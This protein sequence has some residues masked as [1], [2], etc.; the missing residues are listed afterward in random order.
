[1]FSEIN[2]CR[3]CHNANL[4]IVLSLGEQSLTGVFPRNTSDNIPIGPLD[5]VWCTKCG[6]LQLKQSYSLDEMY[7]DNYGYRSGLNAYMVRHLTNKIK[8]LKNLAKL[9]GGD[10]VLDIGSNDATLLKAYPGKYKRVGIDPTGI[11]FK[12]FY[13]DG[14]EVIPDFSPQKF[15]LKNIRTH[16]QKL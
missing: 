3:I 7:G 11:K 9:S 15:L 16:K 2:K 8:T 10:L 4:I 12:D 6:L 14:I 1:M 5:L 13:T